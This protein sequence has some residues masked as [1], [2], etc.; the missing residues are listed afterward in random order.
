MS[1]AKLA[2]AIKGLTLQEARDVG[3]F[4]FNVPF[5]TTDT[6]YFYGAADEDG[7]TVQVEHSTTDDPEPVVIVPD[8]QASFDDSDVYDE[9]VQEAEDV[10]TESVESNEDTDGASGED[11][12][13]DVD[14]DPS[15][16]SE[17]STEDTGE[18]SDDELDA[19]E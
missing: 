1:L 12:E 15:V 6:V 5:E 2:A 16:G 9:G 14:E 13:S 3:Y 17:E 19:E 18:E 7:Q 10:E 11:I 8:D 4:Q